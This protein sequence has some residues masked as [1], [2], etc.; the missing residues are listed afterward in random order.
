MTIHLL[1]CC[2]M[3]VFGA[4]LLFAGIFL[5]LH[6]KNAKPFQCGAWVCVSVRAWVCECLCERE[7]ESVCVCVSVCMAV[8]V[9]VWVCVCACEYVSV[10][11]HV[12]VYKCVYTCAYECVHVCMC[13]CVCA[14]VYW[15]VYV[16]AYWVHF[17]INDWF[18]LPAGGGH[19]KF[20][21]SH[22]ALQ[23]WGQLNGGTVHCSHIYLNT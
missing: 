20:D 4:C 23:V 6:L 2:Q 9:H 3:Y 1:C 15:C 11:V 13:V 5:N 12:W 16:W 18:D 7:S 21:T 14:C 17:F 8:C 10:S 22:R 19:K